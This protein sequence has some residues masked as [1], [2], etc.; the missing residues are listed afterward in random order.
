M[1]AHTPGLV[2]ITPQVL[3]ELR[4]KLLSVFGLLG[5]PAR[6]RPKRHLQRNLYRPKDGYLHWGP[7]P[8]NDFHRA[9]VD[10]PGEAAWSACLRLV[11]GPDLLAIPFAHVS[12][13]NTPEH[14]I[15]EAARQIALLWPT[16]SDDAPRR[17]VKLYRH[18]KDAWNGRDLDDKAAMEPMVRWLSSKGLLPGEGLSV[19]FITPGDGGTL[20]ILRA[21][22]Q[23]IYPHIKPEELD[24]PSW[25]DEGDPAPAGSARPRCGQIWSI[26]RADANVVSFPVIAATMLLMLN[27]AKGMLD[28]DIATEYPDCDISWCLDALH[29]YA[30]M[31]GPPAVKPYLNA[32]DWNNWALE[33]YGDHWIYMHLTVHHFE[34]G[35]VEDRGHYPQPSVSGMKIDRRSLGDE[36][37]GIYVES[38]RTSIARVATARDGQGNASAAATMPDG[39][40]VGFVLTDEAHSPLVVNVNDWDSRG[41]V[42]PAG[43]EGVAF[44]QQLLWNT[45]GDWFDMWQATIAN[46]RRLL[47]IDIK[48][49][50]QNLVAAKGKT[51]FATI[52]LFHQFQKH[53]TAGP[54]DLQTMYRKWK[55]TYFGSGQ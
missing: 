19:A 47:D 21:D 41:L 39:N 25:R 34:S 14:D 7:M 52:Q 40:F 15:K 36:F 2:P 28:V 54:R 11:D 10:I 27:P 35:T 31:E 55:R 50:D 12:V 8:S 43:A 49:L 6:P 20:E 53:I 44:F 16:A 23:M 24:T 26:C 4:D 9:T 13:S 22:N 3:E 17:H 1:P 45:F 29:T 46:R 51:F 37:A 18:S 32:D 38:R 30:R 48:T 42:C 33:T 5:L